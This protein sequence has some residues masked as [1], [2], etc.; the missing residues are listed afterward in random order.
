MRKKYQTPLLAAALLTFA[1]PAVMASPAAE[2]L[3]AEAQQTDAT[4]SGTVIDNTGEP[5]IGATVRVIGNDKAVA[6][7]DVDGH[8]TLKNV[9]V[10]S[11]IT[12]SYIG[13]QDAKLVWAGQN[14]NIALQP[15]ASS[16]DEVVS[17][18]ITPRP[19]RASPAPSLW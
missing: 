17:W 6:V 3:S 18:V 16:L 7:T 5:L 4:C 19:A 13:Y 9:K 14:V 2:P 8:F 12:V 11:T 1:A 10:G 15:A